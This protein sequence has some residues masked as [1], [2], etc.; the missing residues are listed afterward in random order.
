MKWLRKNLL[1]KLFF[2]LYIFA[3]N[4]SLPHSLI[5]SHLRSSRSPGEYSSFKTDD[6]EPQWQ[7][8]R[9]VYP[10]RLLLMGLFTIP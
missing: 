9:T 2:Q 5:F 8:E 6:A 4:M 1:R 10:A 7:S 3:S